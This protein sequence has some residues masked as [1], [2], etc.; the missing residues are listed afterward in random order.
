[1][2]NINLS[3]NLKY[4]AKE[5]GH[6]SLGYTPH[7]SLKV[8]LIN[9]KLIPSMDYLLLPLDFQLL[10]YPRLTFTLF[11]TSLLT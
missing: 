1:M 6:C 4:K 5:E 7:Q 2:H 10:F 11:L 3:R 9:G 8:Y